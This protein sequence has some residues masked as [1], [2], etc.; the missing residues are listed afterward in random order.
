MELNEA[1]RRIF[2]Q[3]WRLILLHVL[4]GA[5]VALAI[6]SD[7]V[8]MY[9]ATTRFVIDAED[10]TTQTES[11]AVSDTA[12]AIATS[13]SQ[14]RAALD[15]HGLTG[16]D[17]VEVGM[18]RVSLRP[19]GTS[20]VLQ[21]SVTD[22][23]REAAAALADELATGVIA[24]RLEVK[25][26]HLRETVR[27]LDR[28]I[29]QLTTRIG[30]LRLAG[31]ERLSE[32]DLLVQR[33]S[34]L[35]TQQLNLLATDALAAKPSILSPATL[36][37]EAVP[38]ALVPDLVLA[39]LLGA[40]LGI[41]L[42]GLL[43]TLWPTLIGGEA[44]AREFDAPLL[45]EL[46]GGPGRALRRD[47]VRRVATRLRL[48]ARAAGLSSVGL[49]ASPEGLEV[50]GLAHLLDAVPADPVTD[51][52][53]YVDAPERVGAVSLAGLAGDEGNGSVTSFSAPAAQPCRIHVFHLGRAAAVVNGN[54]SGLVLVTPSTMKK[55]DV[56][57]SAHLLRI[58][59]APLLGLVTYAPPRRLLRRARRLSRRKGVRHGD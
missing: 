46:S 15:E 39:A 11:A 49:L 56:G 13:P 8:D 50:D 59:P 37:E 25:R 44:L 32:A 1:A 23:S 2:G 7:D 28:R 52:P 27:K 5:G 18:R 45:G 19:L 10:P 57:A 3:H 41:G 40:I 16:R 9:Q 21:L 55:S 12:K 17:P 30:A 42:A 35:E 38:S 58:T 26:G 47:D 24:T 22:P 31:G 36:P 6:H 33:R 43:E 14:V 51:A 34:I 54:A 29:Q 53:V 48:A 4:L 20:G